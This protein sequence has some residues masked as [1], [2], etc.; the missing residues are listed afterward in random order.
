M[1]LFTSPVYASTIRAEGPGTKCRSRA[2]FL[3]QGLL[4]EEGLTD[5]A[6]SCDDGKPLANT[7][8]WIA[9]PTW[10]SSVDSGNFSVLVA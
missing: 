4:P 9:M 10:L 8:A 7:K 3:P 2:L 5:Q 1:L 6:V